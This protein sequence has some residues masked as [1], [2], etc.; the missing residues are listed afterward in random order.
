MGIIKA[1]NPMKINKGQFRFSK[2]DELKFNCKRGRGFFCRFLLNRFKWHYYPRLHHISS[3]PDH[4]D[5]EISSACNMKCPMCYTIT[6]EFKERVGRL[7]MPLELFKKIIDECAEYNVFSIR[8]SLR[9]EPFI[10][11]DV[12]K[13]IAYA[14]QKGI[15][16]ISSLTNG[17]ALTPELFKE[18]MEAGLTWLTISVDGIGETYESIR[19]PAKFNDIVGKIKKYKEIKNEKK[20]IQPVIKV[21]SIWPAIKDNAQKYYDTFSPFA[22]SIAT[23]PLIDYLGK[24][25]EIEYESNFDCPVLYQRMVIGSNGLVLLCSND[26]LGEYILGDANKESLYDIWHGD[27]I[28]KVRELHKKHIGY[29]NVLPCKKCY[30]PRK[31]ISVAEKIGNKKV[32]VDK[33][34]GRTENIGE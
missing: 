7:F 26:E 23:N 21:Q 22:D 27:K 25:K 33:Y 4:V 2:W 19:I 10:H 17:L 28:Q 31:T 9:G 24:D 18:A 29:K 12:I 20:S 14:H 32:F 8:I 1:I 6:D 16:E 30:L 11:P 3:F 13:M 5:I 15:K 34:I